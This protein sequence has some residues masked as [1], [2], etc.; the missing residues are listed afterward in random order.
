MNKLLETLLDPNNRDQ[1][2]LVDKNGK[3]ITFEQVAVVPLTIDGVRSL[4]VVLKPITKIDYVEDDEAIVF[5]V[6]NEEYGESYLCIE[7]D[8]NIAME[9]FKQYY[10][11]LDMA[12]GKDEHDVR[13]YSVVDEP[14]QIDDVP[15]EADNFSQEDVI[16]KNKNKKED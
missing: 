5:R 16:A 4:Y 15:L 6:V 3:E 10:A 12:R 7:E 9:V 2:V 14:T 11:M 13:D 1:I 8:E